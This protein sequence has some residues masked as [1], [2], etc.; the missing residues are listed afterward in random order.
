MQT[1]FMNCTIYEY[2][3]YV[4]G[5]INTLKIKIICV[6]SL[7]ESMLIIYMNYLHHIHE[8]IIKPRFT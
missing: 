3:I 5:I 2:E 8:L 1:A 6:V 7:T 4:K